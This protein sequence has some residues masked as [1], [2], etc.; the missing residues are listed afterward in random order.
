VRSGQPQ[1]SGGAPA[2][3]DPGSNR[4]RSAPAQAIATSLTAEDAGQHR[5][6]TAGAGTEAAA[7]TDQRRPR[8]RAEPAI[9]PQAARRH[10]PPVHPPY[11]AALID[12]ARDREVDEIAAALAG[13]GA[14]KLPR[15]A[16]RVHA[17]LWGPGRFSPALHEAVVQGK[18]H[19]T[20]QGLYALVP[21]APDP[22][23]DLPADDAQHGAGTGNR[24]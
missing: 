13:A 19:R 6:A 12:T 20:G 15:L 3:A 17:D 10:R 4:D 14:I 1:A 8:R 2:G 5:A 7:G 21:S 16:Q 23:D 24:P 22:G 9:T 18:I 11:V